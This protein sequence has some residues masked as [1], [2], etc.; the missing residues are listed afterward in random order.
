V[1]RSL[2]L[3]PLLALT[4]L[5]ASCMSSQDKPAI[6]LT[7]ALSRPPARST[8]LSPRASPTISADPLCASV[9]VVKLSVHD[10]TETIAAVIANNA[11]IRATCGT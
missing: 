1:P 7:P 2:K 4:L 8:S 5:T 6:Q 9:H 3:P 11:A 10:T